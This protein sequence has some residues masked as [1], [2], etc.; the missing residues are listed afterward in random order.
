MVDELLDLVDA[1]ALDVAAHA[2]AVVRHLVDPAAVRI[3][4]RRALRTGSIVRPPV[5]RSVERKQKLFLKKSTC[6]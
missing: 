3:V 5:S 6:P 2:R 1:V 4:V